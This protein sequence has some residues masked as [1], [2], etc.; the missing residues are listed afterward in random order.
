MRFEIFD[1][2]RVAEERHVEELRRLPA[3]RRVELQVLRRGADPLLGAHD[4]ADL[5]E[6]I[7]DDVR[8]VVRREAVRLEQHLIVDLLVLERDLAA[9]AVLDDGL[10]FLRHREA[11]DVGLL[12][13]HAPHRFVLR[14]ATAEAVVAGRFLLCALCSTQCL[15]P[16]LGAETRVRRA[17][18]DEDLRVLRI[19]RRALALAIRA[20]RTADVWPLV[21]RQTD[22]RQRA[23]DRVLRLLRGAGAVGVLDAQHELPTVLL[24]KHVVE[25]RDV[26]RADMRISRR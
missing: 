25:E 5:H 9:E 1:L 22:P 17:L 24:R 6:V 7:V 2:S 21:P 4:V 18:V 3:E 12:R 19:D 23:Q 13:V 11:N 8:E 14:D 16:D 10:T 26:R 15:E 20:V